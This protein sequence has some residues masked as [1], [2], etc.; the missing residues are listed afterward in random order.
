VHEC[1]P[2]TRAERSAERAAENVEGV[3][4]QAFD[5]ARRFLNDFDQRTKAGDDERIVTNAP[6]ASHERRHE[7]ADDRKGDDA[8]RLS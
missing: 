8:I 6:V 3:R 2:R 1:V 7:D 4:G 5:G